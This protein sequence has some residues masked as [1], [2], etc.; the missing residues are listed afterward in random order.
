MGSSRAGTQPA[1][2]DDGPPRRADRIQKAKK[3]KG[4]RQR[5]S[6]FHRTLGQHLHDG[7]ALHLDFNVLGDLDKQD[8]FRS[9]PPMTTSSPLA[10]ASIMAFS[11]FWRFIC[12]RIMM[13][14][15]TTKMPTI[16]RNWTRP[17]MPPAA[18]WARE[19]EEIDT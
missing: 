4:E 17:D 13:K 14:Y 5:R 10:R 7:V 18:A 12:G 16:G 3:R 2:C 15:I 19:T 11:S 9:P 1:P 8:A 6:L